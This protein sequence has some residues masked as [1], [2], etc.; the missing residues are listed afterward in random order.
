MAAGLETQ[1]GAPAPHEE[2]SVCGRQPPDRRA[3]PRELRAVRLAQAV[4][5]PGGQPA[6]EEQPAEDP[7]E[8]GEARAQEERRCDQ[9]W[10]AGRSP[11]LREAEGGEPCEPWHRQEE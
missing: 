5:L 9:R 4:A 8:E 2:G 11:R 10:P 6:D 1:L 7:E 3:D